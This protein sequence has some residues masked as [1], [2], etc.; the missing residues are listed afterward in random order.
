MKYNKMTL[1][2]VQVNIKNIPSFYLFFKQ[3]LF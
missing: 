1:F 3:K 2:T